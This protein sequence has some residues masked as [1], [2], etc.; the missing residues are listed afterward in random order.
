MQVEEG[1]EVC[2]ELSA[3]VVKKAD[4]VSVVE[5]SSSDSFPAST[6]SSPGQSEDIA[7]LKAV[8]VCWV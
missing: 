5:A 8:S 1:Q 7:R 3:F 6:Q 2:A 4:S